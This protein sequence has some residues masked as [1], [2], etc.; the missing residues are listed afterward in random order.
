MKILKSNQGGFTL[1]EL[2]VVVAI[3]SLLSSI[4]LAS[5]KEA[6]EKAKIS[7]LR[8]EMNQLLTAIEL[9]K[10]DKGYYPGENLTKEANGRYYQK[11]INNT[12]VTTS[13][14][15]PLELDG[16]LSETPKYPGLYSTTLT[17]GFYW[18]YLEGSSVKYRCS[19]SNDYQNYHI[20]FRDKN[21]IPWIEKAFPNSA[22]R[23]AY[24]IS[25]DTSIHYTNNLCL[26]IK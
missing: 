20:F 9:Y 4:V 25:T 19:D 21:V 2:L 15:L 13:I 6:R 8:S 14:N 11:A 3:I 5:L 10:T 22:Y 12:D 18:Y 23:I 1:I 16:Y 17:S 7:K 26:S 24:L